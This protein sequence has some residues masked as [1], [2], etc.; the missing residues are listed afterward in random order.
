MYCVI[1]R[2]RKGLGISRFNYSCLACS[3]IAIT[4]FL[5]QLLSPCWGDKIQPHTPTLSVSNEALCLS[6]DVFVVQMWTFALAW[7]SL[8]YVTVT[9]T[10]PG[11]ASP[12]TS[13]DKNPSSVAFV[14]ENYVTWTT[15]QLKSQAIQNMYFKRQINCLELAVKRLFFV[16]LEHCTCCW[17][18]A[19]FSGTI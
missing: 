6:T 14:S 11:A 13:G 7:K 16:L 18:N 4:F 15:L 3:V 10:F 1:K 5:F 9:T 17:M 8:V 12:W 2:S 19:D